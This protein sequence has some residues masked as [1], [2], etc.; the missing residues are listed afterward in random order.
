M[1]RKAMITIDTDM[2]RE[3]FEIWIDNLIKVAAMNTKK[4]F[5]L[6]I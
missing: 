5:T 1:V 3:E 4:Y 2:S 6:V